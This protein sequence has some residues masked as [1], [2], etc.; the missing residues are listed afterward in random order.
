MLDT[1]FGAH[2]K[3]DGRAVPPGPYTKAVHKFVDGETDRLRQDL[4]KLI[5]AQAA[6]IKELELRLAATPAGKLPVVRQW[7]TESVFYACELAVHDGSLWQAKKDSAQKPGGSDWTQLTRAGRDAIRPS[8]RSAFNFA[9][10]YKYLDVVALNGDSFIAR[11]DDPGD[12]PGP[13]WQLLVKG[14][15]GPRGEK[16]DKG[17]AGPR[18]EP[19]VPGP[20]GEPGEKGDLGPPGKLPIV[21]AYQPDT[22]HYEGDVVVHGGAAYQ[23]WRDT[24]CAPPNVDD[25][26]CISSAGRDAITPT[27]HGTYNVRETYRQLTSSASTRTRSSPSMTIPVCAPATAGS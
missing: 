1:Q 4:L 6:R 27:V 15:P 16:G 14:Q 19:G 8:L 5:D 11:K 12:C 23:A 25:W 17:E 3:D 22:V 10:A 7:Q 21:K 2:V 24:A 18:G 20:C 9:E 26:I 13:G